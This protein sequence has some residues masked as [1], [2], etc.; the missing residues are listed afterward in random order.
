ML[1]FPDLPIEGN[2]QQLEGAVESDAM[3]HLNHTSNISGFP[4]LAP[5]RWGS[6]AG[7]DHGSMNWAGPF[8]LDRRAGPYPVRI[9]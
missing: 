3:G 6:I 8:S 1:G 4:P 5:E 7:R 2:T 9:R